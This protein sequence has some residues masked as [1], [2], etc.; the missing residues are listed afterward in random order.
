MNSFNN[1]FKFL[2]DPKSEYNYNKKSGFNYIDYDSYNKNG[3]TE[4]LTKD[5]L[6]YNFILMTLKIMLTIIL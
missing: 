5:L 1:I 3:K 6:K 2:Y 4:L